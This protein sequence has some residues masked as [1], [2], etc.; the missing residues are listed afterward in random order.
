MKRLS[1]KAHTVIDKPTKVA[2]VKRAKQ[3]QRS[4]GAIIRRA[5]DAYLSTQEATE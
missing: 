2:L 5:L 3:E 1:E 4:E